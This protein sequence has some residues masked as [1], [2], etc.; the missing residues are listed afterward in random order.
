MDIASHA[1]DLGARHALPR[2][3]LRAVALH[4]ALPPA[5][6][7]TSMSRARRTA[8]AGAGG[9]A[10]TQAAPGFAG[11]DHVALTVTDLDVSERFYT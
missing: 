5:A 2:L 7:G 4:A 11:I 9:P 3:G 8:T 1:R 10:M 6:D